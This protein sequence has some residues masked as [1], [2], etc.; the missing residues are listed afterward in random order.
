MKR[1]TAWAGPGTPDEAAILKILAAEGLSASLWSNG[2]YDS[3]PAHTHPYHKVLYVVFGSI[4]F[5][6]GGEK[7]TLQAGDRLD[8]PAGCLH[9]AQVG[10]AG[11]VCLEAQK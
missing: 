10:Q 4:T 3:Y 9:D 2:P 7:I 5:G 8:L 1:V 11:V 6:I